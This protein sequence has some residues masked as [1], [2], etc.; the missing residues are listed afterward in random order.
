[1]KTYPK[2]LCMLIL[3]IA[4]STQGRAQSGGYDQS[5]KTAIGLRGGFTSGLTVKHFISGRDALE[6]ILSAWPYDLSITGLY[7]RH[8]SFGSTPGFSFYYGAGAHVRFFTF[9][10][11]EY[12]FY[13]GRYY[14]VTGSTGGGA[15]IGID[16]I[17]GIEYKIP[18]APIAF[19][20]DF[21]PFME[22]GRGGYFLVVPDL[23]LGVKVTF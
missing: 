11:R 10:D 9:Y 6:G 17:A 1:M 18:A 12:Y 13:K 3:G 4:F 15:G 14:I 21:K 23:G 22:F 20:L 2:F 19:S 5:Y 7:E 8:T 16:G